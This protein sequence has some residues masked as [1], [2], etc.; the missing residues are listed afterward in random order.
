MLTV[1][2]ADPGINW[3]RDLHVDVAAAVG[4]EW[5]RVKDA[6]QL[7][8]AVLVRRQVACGHRQRVAGMNS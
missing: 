6:E 4:G 1:V 8:L 7:N 2:I 5:I 3:H